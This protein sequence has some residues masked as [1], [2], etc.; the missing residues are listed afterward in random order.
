MDIRVIS[1][2]CLS[3]HPLWGERS[4]VRAGHA[5]CTLIRGEG[6]GAP[7]IVVD[8]GPPVEMLRARWMERA[9]IAPGAVTHVFLTSFHPETHRGIALFEHAQ[10]LIAESEREGAGVPLVRLLHEA[11]GRGEQALTS[12]LAG[13]VAT[14][15]RCTPAPDSL[16]PGV[17]L[18]PLPGVTPGLSGL[19]LGQDDEQTTLLCGDAVPTVEHLRE[20]QVL[21]TCAD[22]ERARTSFGEAIE[23]ADV[24]VL[25][26]DN[27]IVNE[28][29]G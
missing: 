11:H 17:D 14:L 5:T 12:Q 28:F 24:L 10:W 7:V 1:I 8:P 21:P 13:E 19:L 2:G 4:P 6:K 16:A 29:G 20:R 15:Q 9:G 23:I 26:R 27:A 3:A 25:G 18:F 22:V